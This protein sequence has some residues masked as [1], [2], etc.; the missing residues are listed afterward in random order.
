MGLSVKRVL[1]ISL[2]SSAPLNKVAA[3]FIYGKN[4]EISSSNFEAESG[5]IASR[6]TNF[7]QM[8][9]ID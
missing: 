7:L 6:C 4:A 8:M 9:V 5:Y 2:N 1:T 3:M